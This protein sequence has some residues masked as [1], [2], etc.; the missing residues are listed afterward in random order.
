MLPLNKVT[1]LLLFV[2]ENPRLRQLLAQSILQKAHTVIHG[3][4]TMLIVRNEVLWSQSKATFFQETRDSVL[5]GL[6]RVRA[7]LKAHGKLLFQ[8]RPADPAL[9]PAPQSRWENLDR[10]SLRPFHV[11]S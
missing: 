10:R 5:T 9:S 4:L 3:N 6:A 2:T 11:T 8:D 1:I 7:D